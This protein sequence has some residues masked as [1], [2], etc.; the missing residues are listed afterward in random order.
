MAATDVPSNFDPSNLLPHASLL[1]S[2]IDPLCSTNL[3][4]AEDALTTFTKTLDYYL[5]LP[6][7]LDPVI[8]S[9]L[10]PLLS[11]IRNLLPSLPQSSTFSSRRPIHI[12]FIALY[13]LA[14]VRGPKPFSRLLPHTITDVHF[15]L[16]SLPLF[17]NHP[18][19]K[20]LWHIRYFLYLWFSVAIRIP[21]P[22]NS[23]INNSELST[24]IQHAQ[25][26][27]H[28]IGPVATASA[29]FLARLLSRRDVINVREQIVH[30]ALNV[31]TDARVAALAFLAA[32]F[33]HAQRQDLQPFLEP[34]LDTLELIRGTEECGTKESHL[35]V[36]LATRVALAALPPKVAAWR[37]QR[38]N[39]VAFETH[40]GEV[41]RVAKGV[42]GHIGNEESV[43]V[44]DMEEREV[45]VVERVVEIIAQGLRHQDT[46]VRWSAAKGVGRVTGRLPRDYA[47]E[48]VEEVFSLFEYETGVRKDAVFHGGCLALA[49]LARRGLLLPGDLEFGRA[50]EVIAKAAKFDMR[51]GANSV[52]AHVRDA[53]CYAVWAIARA[54]SKEDVAS[55][56]VRIME[57]MLPVALLDR[58]VNCRR[59]AAAAIQECVGRLG[60]TVFE[61]G[62]RLQQSADYFALG[63]RTAAYLRI[64][65][66]VG[67]LAGG[68]YWGCLIEELVDRKLMHWDAGV[69]M[70]AARA[71]GNVCAVEGGW[72]EVGDPVLKEL[73]RRSSLR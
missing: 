15:L 52:G 38:G 67:E 65:K 7:L 66:E 19:A 70:L 43:I 42:T 24:I 21:F 46:V 53:A 10:D 57:S 47:E 14:K 73:L 23:I 32:L 27:L 4:Q 39:R 17:E 61:D 3:A 26:A 16:S 54:Y 72:K 5:L 18:N 71:L 60:E 28:Q 11:H 9:L 2:L 49:E 45:Q 58:E 37:Y 30:W 36:K 56:G 25:N 22:L 48:V 34:I 20:S 6:T 8:K 64:L 40:L 55:Y 29:Q 13:S 12:P 63:D 50:F 41:R 33:K 44:E 62:I 51:R 1:S 35:V 69:R 68:R 59:A 31:H